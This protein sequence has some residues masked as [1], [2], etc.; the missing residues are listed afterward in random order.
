MNNATRFSPE[1]ELSIYTAAEQKQHLLQVLAEA[2]VA[3]L[4]LSKVEVLDSAG[5]QLLILAKHEA[6]R[7]QK[8]FSIVAQ[9]T[10]VSEVFN[11]C[12]LSGFFGEQVF[13]PSQ[14]ST[15]GET[16]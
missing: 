10:A 3:E 12:N 2:E 16:A 6:Q 1:G 14:A 9:S 8:A 5:L 15:A 13:I 7:L 4:D 11:L